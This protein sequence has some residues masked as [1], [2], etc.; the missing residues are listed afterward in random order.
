MLTLARDFIALLRPLIL[1]VLIAVAPL[2][3]FK[4]PSS[5]S[6]MAF[7][8]VM[9]TF[10]RSLLQKATKASPNVLSFSPNLSTSLFPANHPTTPPEFGTE[11]A[12]LVTSV[13]ASVAV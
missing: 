2:I 11:S 7:I 8:E 3:S 13:P 5:S 1:P 9:F 6:A 10:F 12:N 4:I